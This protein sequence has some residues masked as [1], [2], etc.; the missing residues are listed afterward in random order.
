MPQAAAAELAKGD[1]T[2]LASDLAFGHTIDLIK[3]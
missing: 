1:L 3:R 2:A